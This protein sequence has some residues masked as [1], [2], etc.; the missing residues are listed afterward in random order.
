M[1]RLFFLLIIIVAAGCTQLILK[2]SN[3]AWPIESVV[4]VDND[5]TI[6]DNRY[7]FST[8][9]I[10]LFFAE[11][12]DSSAHQKES[13]RIIRDAKGYYFLISTGFKNVYVFSADD[14]TLV[15]H[16]KI[17]V[18]DFGLDLPAF[19]QRTPY[20]ELLEG[21]EHLLFLNSEGIKE[22]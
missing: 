12:N 14:G 17:L 11:K 13:V 7:S 19:N 22:K 5:G 10:Q 4:D 6:S 3:F 18:S 2:P 9:V 16:N 1:K 15:L 8:N 20:I 21:E